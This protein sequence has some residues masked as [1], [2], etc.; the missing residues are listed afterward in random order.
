M[1]PKSQLISLSAVPGMGPRRIRILFRK[2]PVLED[3]TKLSK[4]D[5]MQVEGISSD[6]A[7]KTK[8]IDLELGKKAE[9]KT[10]SIG[11][12]YLTYWDSGYPEHLKT[13][14]DAPVGVFVIGEIPQCTLSG[15]YGN[16][17]AITLW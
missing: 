14:Y 13:I 1:I 11:A 4:S 15:D 8:G 16:P 5:W 12:R 3:M 9:D 2:F 10:A 17:P 6:L 7:P